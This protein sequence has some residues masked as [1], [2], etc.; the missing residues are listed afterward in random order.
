MVKERRAFADEAVRDTLP[1]E[2]LTVSNR[3]VMDVGALAQAE[4]ARGGLYFNPDFFNDLA[5]VSKEIHD[6]RR[7]ANEMQ[8]R[9]DANAERNERANY[10][11]QYEVTQRLKADT[12]LASLN[13]I[14][15]D[16][17]YNTLDDAYNKGIPVFDTMQK[18]AAEYEEQ[19]QNLFAQNP[20]IGTAFQNSTSKL[21]NQMYASAIAQDKKIAEI[22]ANAVFTNARNYNAAMLAQNKVSSIDQTLDNFVNQTFG[23]LDAL[24]HD[25]DFNYVNAGYNQI[26]SAEIDRISG[27]VTTGE[28]TPEQGIASIQATLYKYARHTLSDG[29]K[30]I[31]VALDKSVYDSALTA[32]SSF[33]KTGPSITSLLL[34]DTFKRDSDYDSIMSG[35]YA[36]STYFMGHNVNS[37]MRDVDNRYQAAGGFA[38]NINSESS[39]KTLL[40][41]MSTVAQEY[42]HILAKELVQYSINET[43]S[44]AKGLKELNNILKTVESTLTDPNADLS[45]LDS[46]SWTSSDGTISLS[47]AFPERFKAIQE[48]YALHGAGVSDPKRQFYQDLLREGRKAQQYLSQDSSVIASMTPGYTQANNQLLGMA[49]PAMLLVRDPRSGEIGVNR[50]NAAEFGDLLKQITDLRG[51]A[52]GNT[53]VN[54]EYQSLIKTITNNMKNQSLDTQEWFKFAVAQ[55]AVANDNYAILTSQNTALFSENEQQVAKDLAMYG[56]LATTPNGEFIMGQILKNKLG[57]QYPN[58]TMS[59]ANSIMQ[60]KYSGSMGFKNF[61]E[62]V[63]KTLNKYQVPERYRPALRQLA[64]QYGVSSVTGEKA[65]EKFDIK[66]FEQVVSSNFKGG[67]Y[68]YHPTFRATSLDNV[69]KNRDNAQKQINSALKSSGATG[70]VILK[71]NPDSGDLQVYSS[72]K[73]L[74][75]AITGGPLAPAGKASIS[76]VATKPV[77]MNDEQFAKAQSTMFT[78]IGIGAGLLEVDTNP[79]IQK[80][81][82]HKSFEKA[83]AESR[84]RDQGLTYDQA[85]KQVYKL[86]GT[87]MDPE[88]Q[89]DWIRFVASNGSGTRLMAAPEYLRNAFG[90]FINVPSNITP[91]ILRTN[92]SL[93]EI[94]EGYEVRHS[95]PDNF[96]AFGGETGRQERERWLRNYIDFAYTRMATKNTVR[97]DEPEGMIYERNGFDFYNLETKVASYPELYTSAGKTDAQG[98]ELGMPRTSQY[99]HSGQGHRDGRSRDIAFKAGFSAVS[100]PD[101]FL[102]K[103]NLAIL[104]DVA[105]ST[106]GSCFAFLN[107]PALGTAKPNMTEAEIKAADPTGEFA[108]YRNLK[109]VDGKPFFRYYPGHASHV[110]L[111]LIDRNKRMFDDQGK[112]IKPSTAEQ[113]R[114]SRSVYNQAEIAKRNLQDS[115]IFVSTED[116]NALVR[117]S[118]IL[119]FKPNEWDAR[120]TGRRLDEINGSKNVTGYNVA[121]MSRYKRYVSTFGNSVNNA[122][123]GL[124]GGRFKIIQSDDFAKPLG[125]LRPF[126]PKFLETKRTS[127][128]SYLKLPE[129]R[130]FSAEEACDVDSALRSSGYDPRFYKWVPVNPEKYNKQIEIFVRARRGAL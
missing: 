39:Q 87:M 84:G 73:L 13:Q 62:A 83:I 115:G 6:T 28:Q 109:A 89:R 124:N 71:F 116:A 77:E 22:N 90:N 37:F 47:F 3:P 82:V 29:E 25:Y 104:L 110:H 100:G 78:G 98:Y 126:M 31:D 56:F 11:Q 118:N 112:T 94:S 38:G 108:Y 107:H 42:P 105:D 2:S 75:G 21:M 60:G 121:L 5:Y 86:V 102:T 125:I 48:Y 97:I 79:N 74:Q 76:I 15:I 99:R 96:A 49:N 24:G 103:P 32:I 66:D 19:S 59:M 18:K 20:Y 1:T 67:M 127:S 14:A 123:I 36:K 16:D 91:N 111:E 68:R 34:L 61:D 10:L 12:E 72:N 45:V 26:V 51:K 58:P 8:F 106:K 40:G 63:N 23:S 41:F 128:E 54:T 55:G 4:Q 52:A 92:L 85:K 119:N 27:L 70:D 9:N 65:N 114:I 81:M 57:G 130:T 113:D 44:P 122:V 93:E 64:Y 69:I 80:R 43:G 120:N 35:D 129:N 17:L 7:N 46:L 88:F 33:K 95:I 50:Q 30:I 101:G 117:Y 53:A